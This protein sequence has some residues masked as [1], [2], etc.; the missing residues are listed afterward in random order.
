[1]ENHAVIL[2]KED[3]VEFAKKDF[4]S[5]L[6]DRYKSPV[7]IEYIEPMG[8]GCKE[9]YKPKVTKGNSLYLFFLMEAVVTVTNEDGAVKQE[10]YD[11][12]DMY[13]PVGYKT[14][15]GYFSKKKLPV[16][17]EYQDGQRL[18]MDQAI[19][20][21]SY[22]TDAKENTFDPFWHENEARRRNAAGWNAVARDHI[23]DPYCTR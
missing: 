1:M 22:Q 6:A 8:T 23:T 12:H 17:F 2:T 15:K 13:I 19:E 4:A 7:T 16:D 5:Y 9:G 20:L 21:M 10:K 14:P 3:L 18:S 11:C